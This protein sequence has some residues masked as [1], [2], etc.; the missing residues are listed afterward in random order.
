MS[1]ADSTEYCFQ[2]LKGFGRKEITPQELAEYLREHTISD[3]CAALN[4]F[5]DVFGPGVAVAAIELGNLPITADE[6]DQLFEVQ[7]SDDRV[8]EFEAE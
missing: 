4:A 3:V 5:A 1:A 8:H 2:V 6:R 7:D